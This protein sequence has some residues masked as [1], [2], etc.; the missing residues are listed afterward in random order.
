MRYDGGMD[1]DSREPLFQFR[2]RTL[3]IWMAIAAFFCTAFV[4]GSWIWHALTSSVVL[5]SIT[6]AAVMVIAT[7]GP[8]RIFF[9]AF[10]FFTVA[11]AATVSGYLGVIGLQNPDLPLAPLIRHVARQIHA[12]ASPIVTRDPAR[13]VVNSRTLER[14]VRERGQKV[15]VSTFIGQQAMSI[16]IGAI[17]AYTCRAIYVAKNRKPNQG[18]TP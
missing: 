7:H 10:L 18:S 5:I 16:L 9:V 3:L 13:A 4:T 1:A 14:L 15:A 2:I 11:Y 8:E 17:A 6:F 12:E